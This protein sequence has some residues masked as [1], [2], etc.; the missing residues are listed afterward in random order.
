MLL[1]VVGLPADVAKT[2]DAHIFGSQS[3]EG[4]TAAV[5]MT[6]TSSML[7]PD[8]VPIG[9]FLSCIVIITSWLVVVYLS[10]LLVVPA[11]M[12]R[13]ILIDKEQA[14][15]T[16]GDSIQA[17]PCRRRIV[18]RNYLKTFSSTRCS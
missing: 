5:L 4:N 13:D 16:V 12:R 8:R 7:H 11:L 1:A 17:C 6:I 10:G 9:V 3:E 18:L 14:I 15:L 2:L